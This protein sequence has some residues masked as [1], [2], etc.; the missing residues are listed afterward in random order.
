MFQMNIAQF[1]IRIFVFDFIGV[2]HFLAD[3]LEVKSTYAFGFEIRS[4]ARCN[5]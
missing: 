2:T 3:Y 5:F 4:V 1:V